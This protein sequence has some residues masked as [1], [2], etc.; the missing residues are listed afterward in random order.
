MNDVDQVIA[1]M[2]HMEPNS[3]DAKDK[4]TKT[5][6]YLGERKDMVDYGALKRGGYHIGSGGIE[7]WLIAD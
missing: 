2:Q 7:S 6:R 4:I 3:D 1:N 5:V